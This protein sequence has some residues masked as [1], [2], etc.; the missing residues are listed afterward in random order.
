MTLFALLPSLIAA[1]LFAG[2][3]RMRPA[4][5]TELGRL[6]IL[7]PPP[8]SPTALPFQETRSS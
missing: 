8:T 3:F 2:T 5:S 7:P 4:S 6:T 1:A